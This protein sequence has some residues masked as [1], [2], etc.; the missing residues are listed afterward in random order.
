MVHF[1]HLLSNYCQAWKDSSGGQ[2][3][4]KGTDFTYKMQHIKCTIS[5]HVLLTIIQFP[6]A[7]LRQNETKKHSNV[8]QS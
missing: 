8:A 6:F 1:L 7:L 4:D 2:M 5:N 3:Q